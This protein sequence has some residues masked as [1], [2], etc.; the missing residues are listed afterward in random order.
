MGSIAAGALFGAATRIA[1]LLVR[2]L[3]SRIRYQK[4]FAV[5]LTTVKE[6]LV[7]HAPV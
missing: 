7:V 4:K 3:P 1:F 2:T 6:S 5:A